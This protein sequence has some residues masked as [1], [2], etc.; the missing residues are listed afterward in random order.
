MIKQL[1]FKD[2]DNNTIHGGL[3]LENG[4]VICGCCGAIQEHDDEEVTWKRLE[5]FDTWEDIDEAIYGDILNEYGDE[6]Y[7]EDI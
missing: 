6:E 3:L 4:D 1:I 2:L 5:V 7:D